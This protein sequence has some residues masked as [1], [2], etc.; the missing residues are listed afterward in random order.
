MK[1]TINTLKSLALLTLVLT[2]TI[3]CDKDF[4]NIDSDIEGVRNF[5]ANSRKFPLVTYTKTV[6]PFTFPGVQDLN[7]VQSNGL[8][9]NIFGVYKDPNDLEFG[10]TT[11]S[12]LSQILPTEFDKDFGEN[13][14]V[15]SVMLRVPYFSTLL[16]TNDAGENAYELDSLYG[17]LTKPFKL[18][19]YR[20]NYLLRALDPNTNFEEPQAYYSNQKELFDSQQGTLLFESDNFQPSSSEIEIFSDDLD[21]DT[22]EP[23]VEERLE[24]S[25]YL[26]L[27]D[28]VGLSYWQ[29]LIDNNQGTAALSNSSNFTDFFRG[30]Y[31]K[32]EP[33]DGSDEGSLLFLNFDSNDARIVID[34]VNDEEINSDI[35][36]GDDI[37]TYQFNFNG[38]RVNTFENS[39]V[40]NDL[41]G[42]STNGDNNLY[43][44]GG[45]GTMAVID[46]FN[47]NVVNDEGA[48]QDALTFFNS[49]KEKW[50][51]N[52]AN[53]IFYVDQN[54][55]AGDE[56]ER[57]L[58]F[59]LKNNVP[60]VDYFLDG[61]TNSTNPN[62]SKTLY[63]EK[64]D[65]D[66]D[67]NGIRY[68]FRLTNHI[69]NMLQRDS[70]NVK[71]GLYV[72]SNVNITLNNQIEN[73][74]LMDDT[75]I[76]K[77]PS[78]SIIA[79]KSTI[80]HGSLPSLPEGQRAEFEIY[81]TEPEN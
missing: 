11:A 3:A 28:I 23:V 4:A 75:V 44:K 50:L 73:P 48:T 66:S 76:T 62:E 13:P 14:D 81:F 51:V 72:T 42:D 74:N 12:V 59:D 80:L 79:P 43:L 71:L 1:K 39:N 30:I 21:P 67:D 61:T 64:L 49:K 27:T 19:I 52:E 63:A 36:F 15:K 60:I 33:A 18:S 35:E 38:I 8:P 17:D 54:A 5:N 40:I 68:K 77:V 20:S 58:L 57:L 2:V 6:T 47:G 45:D 65:R 32:V 16:N 29:D 55:V 41:N 7:G 69:N 24:P 9:N 34:Y 46:L 25:L 22:G 78:S 70:T 53:L 26:D 56:P 31:F 10:T 37:T